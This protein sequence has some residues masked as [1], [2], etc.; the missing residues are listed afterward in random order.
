VISCKAELSESA[1]EAAWDSVKDAAHPRLLLEAPTSAVQMEYLLGC[2]P[3]ALLERIPTLISYAASLCPE[4]EFSALDATR[5]EPDFLCDVLNAA[6][7]AGA[8][9]I[10][11]CDTAGSLLPDELSSFLSTL[12][13]IG[14]HF[15]QKL[16]W[17]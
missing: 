11:V 4:V 3:K 5:S 14:P 9:V 15:F 10:T 1:I 7:Q 13:E 8:K 2:K 6:I 16:H 17:V 12:F